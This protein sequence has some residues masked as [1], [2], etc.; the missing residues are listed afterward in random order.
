MIVSF[1]TIK[2][3]VIYLN[4]VMDRYFLIAQNGLG[5]KINYTEHLFGQPSKIVISL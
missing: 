3:T 4:A 1:D 2:D 5:L